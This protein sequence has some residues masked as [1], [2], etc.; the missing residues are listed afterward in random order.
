MWF[1]SFCKSLYTLKPKNWQRVHFLF[2]FKQHWVHQTSLLV[3]K[4]VRI[5]FSYPLRAACEQKCPSL[6]SVGEN[7]P[8]SLRPNSSYLLSETQWRGQRSNTFT[9]TPSFHMLMH[10]SSTLGKHTHS[11]V[12]LKWSENS[13]FK[14]LWQTCLLNW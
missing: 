4:Q 12:I 5:T 14:S 6:D 1:E 8:V 13:L 2:V 3:K 11:L 9:G 7:R 10:C